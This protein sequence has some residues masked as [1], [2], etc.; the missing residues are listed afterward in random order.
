MLTRTQK[1]A[2][3]EAAVSALSGPTLPP[4]GEIA[5]AAGVPVDQVTP[6]LRI[7]GWPHAGKIA[8]AVRMF[9]ATA[10]EDAGDEPPATPAPTP[11]VVPVEDS[12][13][14]LLEQAAASRDSV[15]KKLG[16]RAGDLIVELKARVAAE[17]DHD[18]TI[19]ADRILALKKEIAALERGAP[20][21]PGLLP[22]TRRPRAIVVT[23]GGLSCPT[24]GG[25]F[26]TSRGLAGH[27]RIVHE[28]FRLAARTP[29]ESSEVAAASGG[30]VGPA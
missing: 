26:A 3:L 1:L 13:R 8:S 6:V 16:A 7:H 20:L 12:I 25:T 24:C 30:S 23:T 21:P 5:A 10:D 29:R 15:T 11:A 18:R 14:A 9:R 17:K 2:I 4:V 28:G 19:R 27:R 22:R